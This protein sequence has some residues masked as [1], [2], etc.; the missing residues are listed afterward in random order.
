MKVFQRVFKL[1]V[2]I[3]KDYRAEAELTQEQLAKEIEVS[4]QTI[5]ALE[6]GNYQPSIEV[7][8]RLVQFFG[9]SPWDLL[10]KDDENG[11]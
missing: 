5:S 3:M 10:I 6:N 2:W 9:C 8:F 1:D 7:F 4:R 11:C